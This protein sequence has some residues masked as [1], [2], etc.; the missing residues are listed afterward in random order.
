MVHRIMLT[1]LHMTRSSLRMLSAASL[2]RV[3]HSLT[4]VQHSQMRKYTML[5]LTLSIEAFTSH[6]H[7]HTT[8]S[9]LHP[10]S[11]VRGCTIHTHT[12]HP[13]RQ[14]VEDGEADCYPHS[15]T[16]LGTRSPLH[17]CSE[18][19]GLIDTQHS[20]RHLHSM[21]HLSTLLHPH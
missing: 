8:L 3:C 9:R 15:D 10:H 18:S 1:L 7:T 6:T 19:V 17:S 5:S 14:A 11:T 16:P 4:T 12:T 21:Y 2:T 13:N 20:V